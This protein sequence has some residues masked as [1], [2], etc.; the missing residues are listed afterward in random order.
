MAITNI[1]GAH[2]NREVE[3]LRE[4][5]DLLKDQLAYKDKQIEQLE[6]LNAMW[7]TA[8]MEIY[9]ASSTAMK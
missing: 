2:S 3:L 8:S 4:M 7:M 5:I 6:K 1:P 9:A